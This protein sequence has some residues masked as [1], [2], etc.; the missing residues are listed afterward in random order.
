MV[1]LKIW[2]DYD[3]WCERIEWRHNVPMLIA[4]NVAAKHNYDK[5]QVICNETD[6]ILMEVRNVNQ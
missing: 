3:K 4:Y 5:V 6:E 1:T 2:H